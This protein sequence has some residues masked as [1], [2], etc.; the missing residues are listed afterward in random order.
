MKLEWGPKMDTMSEEIKGPREICKL[1]IFL[2][3]QMEI[4]ELKNTASKLKIHWMRLT[5]DCSLW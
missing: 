1:Y 2:K 5:E 3:N 4:Q